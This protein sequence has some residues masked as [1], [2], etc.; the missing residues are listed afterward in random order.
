MKDRMVKYS[1]TALLFALI[2]DEGSGEVREEG[3]VTY[4]LHDLDREH[5]KAWLK[6][7]LRILI[8]AGA[9]EVGTFQSDGQKLD[10]RG[11]QG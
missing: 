10:C 11:D 6:Q 5:L 9:A 4:K 2:R 8:G 3:K 7:T 1:R